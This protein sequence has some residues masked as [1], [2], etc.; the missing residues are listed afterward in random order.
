MS[1]LWAVS[2]RPLAFGSSSSINWSTEALFDEYV[3]AKAAPLANK[4]RAQAAPIPPLAV[5]GQ[6]NGNAIP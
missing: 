2:L 5:A 3:R 6:S 1:A 4:S